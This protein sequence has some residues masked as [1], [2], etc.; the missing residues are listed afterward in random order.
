MI[1]SNKCDS[2]Q[3]IFLNKRNFFM[4]TLNELIFCKFYSFWDELWMNCLLKIV[5]LNYFLF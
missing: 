1:M 5:V 3:L 4:L 2:I